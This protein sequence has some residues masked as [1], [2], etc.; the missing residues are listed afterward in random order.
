M[1][2]CLVGILMDVT[3]K[4]GIMRALVLFLS[5]FQ[6]QVNKVNKDNIF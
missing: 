4:K 6:G 5:L 2:N 3:V 1:H